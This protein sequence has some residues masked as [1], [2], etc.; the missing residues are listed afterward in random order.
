[1][2]ILISACFTAAS[3]FALALVGIIADL[4]KEKR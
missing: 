3:A 1:M 4:G 2:L